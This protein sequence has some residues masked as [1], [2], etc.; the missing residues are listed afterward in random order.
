[1]KQMLFT[2]VCV[3][4]SVLNVTGCSSKNRTP[5]GCAITVE[6][7]PNS[8]ISSESAEQIFAQIEEVVSQRTDLR[9]IDR[10]RTDQVKKELAFQQSDW[11]SKIKTA[12]IGDALNAVLI[13]LVTIY[14]DSYKVE[15]LNVKSWQKR[16]YNGKVSVG[17]FRVR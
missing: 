2:L 8:S 11:S 6:I 3:A 10:E 17:F 12:K 9:L 16:T 14:G 7:N 5:V 4:V 15:F 1:M 13:C